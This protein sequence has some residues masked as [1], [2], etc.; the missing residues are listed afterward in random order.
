[1]RTETESALHNSVQVSRHSTNV[2]SLQSHDT[3]PLLPQHIPTQDFLLGQDSSTVQPTS[4]VYLLIYLLP[5][6]ST[7]HLILL[8]YNS[9]WTASLPLNLAHIQSIL[10]I[11]PYFSLKYKSGHVTFL[12]IKSFHGSPNPH[13]SEKSYKTVHD[14]PL[15]TS[16]CSHLSPQL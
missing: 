3:F 2:S 10:Y 9:L 13:P 4:L 14:W 16:P 7:Y 5:L 15:V 12:I 6:F 1:M 11:A 8:D